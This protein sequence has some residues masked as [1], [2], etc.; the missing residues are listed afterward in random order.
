MKCYKL[1]STQKNDL[2]LYISLALSISRFLIERAPLGEE[3]IVSLSLSLLSRW[4][5][6]DPVSLSSSL[7]LS[8]F[9]S[10][11]L[12]LFKVFVASLNPFMHSRVELV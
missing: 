7:S 2:K 3:E 12:S 10:L 9:L 4:Y 6:R 8:L 1:L 5:A 11:S